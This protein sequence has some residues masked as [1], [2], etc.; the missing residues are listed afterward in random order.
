MLPSFRQKEVQLP[1]KGSSCDSWST[2]N[3]D[4]TWNQLTVA[5]AQWSKV[6]IML[7]PKLVG[8]DTSSRRCAVA[9]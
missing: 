5:F 7:S 3:K 9:W 6:V 1:G 8:Q 4:K 2:P